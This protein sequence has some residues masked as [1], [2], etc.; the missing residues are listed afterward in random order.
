MVLVELQ[1][2]ERNMHNQIPITYLSQVTQEK[3]E[4]VDMNMNFK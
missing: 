1:G 2:I 3:E 4:E